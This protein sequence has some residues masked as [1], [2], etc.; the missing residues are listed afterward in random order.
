MELGPSGSCRSVRYKTRVFLTLLWPGLFWKP[1]FGV[2]YWPAQTVHHEHTMSI[3]KTITSSLSWPSPLL[4]LPK[5]IELLK[6]KRG[7]V[8]FIPCS[9]LQITRRFSQDSFQIAGRFQWLLTS[10]LLG[11]FPPNHQI[12]YIA[13]TPKLSNNHVYLDWSCL[14][15]SLTRKGT[16]RVKLLP[17]LVSPPLSAKNSQGSIK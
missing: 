8:G 16:Y 5:T 9:S 10:H 3:R 4:T 13:Q 15:L 2:I 14:Y 1:D 6:L 11:F 7:F 17:M 12:I